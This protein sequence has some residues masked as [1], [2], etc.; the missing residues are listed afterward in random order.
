M[1]PK[2]LWSVTWPLKMCCGIRHQDISGRTFKSCRVVSWGLHGWDMHISQM[3][4]FQLMSR[5]FFFKKIWNHSVWKKWAELVICISIIKTGASLKMQPS[6]WFKE[7]LKTLASCWT[8]LIESKDGPQESCQADLFTAI[9]DHY[10]L[11]PVWQK[12]LFFISPCL[13][14]FRPKKE[15]QSTYCD[16]VIP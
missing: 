16:T 1:P 9:W 6:L 12:I 11:E 10:E 14:E 8:W 7:C 4:L 13:E 3:I 2:Q 5:I 15:Q